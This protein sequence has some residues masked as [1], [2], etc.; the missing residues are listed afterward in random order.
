MSAARKLSLQVLY[1]PRRHA[2]F[3]RR[4]G[5]RG[6]NISTSRSRGRTSRHREKFSLQDLYLR[7][8]RLRVRAIVGHA[9]HRRAVGHH[10]HMGE[11]DP[12][13]RSCLPFRQ[14]SRDHSVAEDQC[15]PGALDHRP[16]P[17]LAARHLLS[18]RRA[19]RAELEAALGFALQLER[20]RADATPEAGYVELWR[21][22]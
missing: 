5:R 3:H 14:S 13:G 15:G 11:E 7:R 6:V 17:A 20:A 10:D 9:A 21:R 8:S 1:P 4:K 16:G 12:G 19:W 22:S 2:S 18:R